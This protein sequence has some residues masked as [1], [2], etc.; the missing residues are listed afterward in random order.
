M[1][2][3]WINHAGRAEHLMVQQRLWNSRTSDG[4]T[5]EH[6][7]VERWNR[8]GRTVEQRWGNSGTSD[9]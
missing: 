9:G 4:A 1:V 2:E 7:M 3:Q 6:L 8:D 5:V